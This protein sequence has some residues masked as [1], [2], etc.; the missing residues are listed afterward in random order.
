MR[1]LGSTP[2]AAGS[3]SGAEG[4]YRTAKFQADSALLRELGERLVGQPHIALA[5]L[6][7]NAYDADATRC[8]ISIDKDRITVD[9]RRSWYD[10]EGVPQSLD[11]DRYAKQAGPYHQS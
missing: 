9:R 4:D 8:T 5:E 2:T 6:I 3:P 10:R 7:K 1:R 11:D